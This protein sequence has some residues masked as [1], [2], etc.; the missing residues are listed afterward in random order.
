MANNVALGQSARTVGLIST[1]ALVVVSLVVAAALNP[2]TFAGPV[3]TFVLCYLPVQIV[4]AGLWARRP[5]WLAGKSRAVRGSVLLVAGLVI[6]AVAELV[7]VATVGAGQGPSTP[8]IAMFS[9]VAVV[10]TFL[11]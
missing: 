2:A 8:Q 10:A 6:G 1:A 3:A 4:L 9:I 5:D 11:L 7:F